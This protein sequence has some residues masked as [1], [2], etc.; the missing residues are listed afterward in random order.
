MDISLGAQKD[1][2]TGSRCMGAG[3]LLGRIT[4][5]LSRF[6]LALED[7]TERSVG[8]SVSRATGPAYDAA[9]QLEKLL[10]KARPHVKSLMATLEGYKDYGTFFGF[11]KQQAAKALAEAEKHLSAVAQMALKDCGKRRPGEGEGEALLQMKRVK[12]EKAPAR[13]PELMTLPVLSPDQ[14]ENVR[15]ACTNCGNP[16]QGQKESLCYTCWSSN[17][18][19][20]PKASESGMTL[21]L[22]A[23]ESG[24]ALT[25][26]AG[27]LGL[28]GVTYLVG[29]M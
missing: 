28:I 27:V 5:G 15:K 20:A 11:G 21:G 24:T 1:I 13:T 10:P 26:I 7:K 22:V 16:V 18:R 14:A 17:A 8:Y 29:R 2:Y 23:S 6:G 4:A 3:I 25:L 12:R 19:T 9:K